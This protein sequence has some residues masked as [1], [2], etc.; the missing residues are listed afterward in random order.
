M[1]KITKQQL[2]SYL[3][4]SANIL[5]G[6]IDSGD[7]KHYILG[8][9]FYK[10][11][12]DVFDEEYEKL[13]D[14]VGEELA[15]DENLYADVF[16]I[17]DGCHWNDILST[18][19][20]TGEK[21]NDVFD[22]VTKANT[23]RLDGILNKIDFADKDKLSDEA[24][25][26]LV[27]HFNTH[28]LGNELIS[29]DMLGDAYEYLIAQFADDAG[30]KG[31]EFYTPH[32]IV[33]LIVDIL[34]PEENESIYDPA[35]GSGGMLVT[36]AQYLKSKGKNDK[37]IFLYGQ[38]GVYATY[39][40]AKM[41]MILHGYNDAKIE[42]GDTFGDP[43]HLDNGA[44][45]KFD[46]VLANPPWNLDDWMH[47][48]Q[49][50]NGKKK[51]V[52]VEDPFNRLVF[53]RPPAS[54]GDWAWIQHMYA[55]LNDN[56]RIGVVMDN[57][58]LFR[59]SSEGKIRKAFVEED[60]IDTVIGLPANLFANTGSPGCILIL[61]KKKPAERK[62][63]ILF[64][65]ASK[66]YLEGKAQ[67]HLRD[68]DLQKTLETYLKYETVERYC[69]VCEL[70]EIEEND[71]NLNISRYVDTTEPEVPVIIEN[72]MSELESLEKEREDNNQKLSAYLKELGY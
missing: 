54:S 53:G 42:R 47:T 43:R 11:L 62:G 49:T 60:L 65:D 18:S 33:E 57:G 2:Q 30:K 17:P 66:D 39:I 26:S 7:F 16:F 46:M 20:N 70:E 64:I 27:N 61:N 51:K 15:K 55:S 58:V 56:G 72:V 19:T 32:K 45:K 52:E 37:R 71:F 21:I 67:N 48:T 13:K 22:K 6:K 8:L 14:Q 40:L 23:P 38:E 44:L 34:Q 24:V 59:G 68:E 31:G 10:R 63:K 41:N 12:S 69:S 1:S 28:K 4:E 50:V 3:W 36:S 9:L 35:C 5:R 25:N 29:G